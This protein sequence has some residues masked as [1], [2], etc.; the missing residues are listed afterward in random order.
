[1]AFR[2][3]GTPSSRGVLGFGLDCAAGPGAG[4]ASVRPSGGGVAR[5]PYPGQ[6]LGDA[7]CPFTLDSR[8]WPSTDAQPPARELSVK[9]I[10]C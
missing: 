9:L 10:L 6:L 8:T 7:T 1:M 4:V 5:Q 3:S 2:F